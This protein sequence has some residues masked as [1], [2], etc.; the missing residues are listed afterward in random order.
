VTSSLRELSLPELALRLDASQGDAAYLVYVVPPDEL[1]DV[2]AELLAE[3]NGTEIPT[4]SIESTSAARL[5]HELSGFEGTL[6]LNAGGYRASDWSLLDRRRSDL[7]RVG[8]TVFLTTEESFD[9]LMQVAPNL[10]SWLGGNAFTRPPSELQATQISNDRDE[11]RAA[12]RVW[13]G[14]SDADVIRRAEAH[15]LPLDPEYAEW[16]VLLGRGDLLDE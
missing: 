13:S 7:Q 10:A 16:L 8:P 4:I 3:L 11:R 9:E 14:M 6:V 1:A 15:T 2:A 12:L 5:L